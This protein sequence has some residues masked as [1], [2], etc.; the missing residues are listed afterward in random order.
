MKTYKPKCGSFNC[1]ET[2][3]KPIGV[4][5][6]TNILLCNSCNKELIQYGVISLNIG[7]RL[8]IMGKKG[9]FLQIHIS[10]YFT[11]NEPTEKKV[12]VKEPLTM[13]YFER[14]EHRNLLAQMD[15][16]STFNGTNDNY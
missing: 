10:N 3:N 1:K 6:A 7:K 16:K 8:V 15:N 9:D 2:A 12:I 5:N 14:M 4:Q 13:D 11:K